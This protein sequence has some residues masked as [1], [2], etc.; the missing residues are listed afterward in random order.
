MSIRIGFGYEQQT[1]GLYIYDDVKGD[2]VASEYDEPSYEECKRLCDAL[3]VADP[4]EIECYRDG[5]RYIR[6][7]DKVL[8]DRHGNEY[9]KAPGYENVDP[10]A[11]K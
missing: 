2:I 5:R 1:P 6:W 11:S 3:V 9:G 4:E 10:E 7:H 8:V